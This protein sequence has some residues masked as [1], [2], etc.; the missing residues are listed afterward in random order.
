[1]LGGLIGL[2]KSFSAWYWLY[3]ALEFLEAAVGDNCSPMF[4]LS[5]CLAYNALNE[6]RT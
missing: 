1:M 4:I 3:I 6:K 2:A 5:K